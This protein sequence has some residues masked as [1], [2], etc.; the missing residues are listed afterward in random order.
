MKASGDVRIGISGWNYKP[1]RGIFYPE[2]LRQKDELNYAANTFR[3]IEVNGTFYSLQRPNTFQNWYDQTPADFVFTIKGS[4]FITHVRRLRNVE[5]PLANFFASGV[6]A[7]EEK[8]GP[9]LWQLPPNFHYDDAEVFDNFFQL[10]PK[11]T[12]E[13]AA[14]AERHE[15]WMK[16][17]RLVR[18]LHTTRLHHALEIRHKSFV[19]PEFIDLL[20]KHNVSLVCADAV[21]WPLLM[22]VT[23]DF[24]YCRLHGSEVLYASGYDE[25]AI[26]VWAKRVARWAKGE[27]VND[28]DHASPKPATKCANRDVYVFFDNDAKVRAP[29]DAKSLEK[30]VNQLL[31]VQKKENQSLKATA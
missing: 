4:R 29:E 28:G 22:D 20:R 3:S 9:I 27:E 24:V 16:G 18:A 25:K 30:A 11:D 1:W 19:V 7:L 8:F 26:Q 14:L 5:T 6:L 31:G 15:G 10:L 2:K 17:R 23:A 21:E 12:E 13:A